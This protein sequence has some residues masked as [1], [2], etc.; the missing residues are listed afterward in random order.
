MKIPIN[1]W[2]KDDRPRE[3]LLSK[4]VSVLTDAELIAILIGSGN[5]QESA[6]SLSQRILQDS[7]NNLDALGAFS[8][9]DLMKY[10]GIGG[11]KAISIIAAL[12]LGRR[13][14]MSVAMERKTIKSSQDAFDI[15]SP[16]L[17]DLNT[18]SFWVIYMK[19]NSVAGLERV[20]QGGLDGSMVDVRLLMK[21]LLEKEATAFIIA[22]NHP[23]GNL[24]PSTSDKHLT[25]K[26]KKAADLLQIHLLDHIIV[27][28]RNF[29]S[30]VDNGLWN[31]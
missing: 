8:I 1:Q 3:K 9:K 24:Q 20:S 5:R 26:I 11:A 22:H 14:N 31:N 21:F 13:R 16:K 18:E 17:S 12:E 2:S 29:F 28:G 19:K 23:S 7:D 6:V 27:A 30:F 4:G 25:V 15:L 10:K